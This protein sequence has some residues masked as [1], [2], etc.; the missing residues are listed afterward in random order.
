M[1]I[2]NNIPDICQ[3]KRR[4]FFKMKNVIDF[5]TK[6]HGDKKTPCFLN[7]KIINFCTFL[8]PQMNLQPYFPNGDKQNEPHR[9]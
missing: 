5:H 8:R 4:I 1:K 7:F 2:K 9:K 3:S 6:K